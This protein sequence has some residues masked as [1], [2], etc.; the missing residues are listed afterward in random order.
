MGSGIALTA[1]TSGEARDLGIAASVIAGVGLVSLVRTKIGED[2][3]RA[4][5]I[6]QS[7]YE[8]GKTGRI[9]DWQEQN[10][11]Y[12]IEEFSSNTYKE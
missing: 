11:K 7:G 12:T 10:P 1:L 6:Y 4:K 9:V 8:D 5:E 2:H 3:A